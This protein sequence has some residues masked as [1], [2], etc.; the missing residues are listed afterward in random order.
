MMGKTTTVD[1]KRPLDSGVFDLSMMY[2]T[3]NPITK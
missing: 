2:F 1:I 3:V